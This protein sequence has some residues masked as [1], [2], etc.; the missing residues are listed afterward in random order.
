MCKKEIQE[1]WDLISKSKKILLINHIRMDMDSLWSLSA[2]YDVL[3]QIWK[4]VKAINDETPPNNYNIIWYNGIIEPYMDIAS[5]KPDLI[6]S[7]DAASEWQLWATF[8]N[9]ID[10]FKNT[11]LVVVDHHVS[12]LWFG[13]LNIIYP[14]FSSTCEIVY[15]ILKK[16]E[17]TKYITPKIATA[18]LA[19]VYTDTNI[20]YNSNTN[21]HT[22]RTAA[23]LIDFWAD[24]RKP[25]FEFYKKKT[26]SKSRLWWS[27]LSKRLK[28]SDNKKVAWATVPFSIFEE[29]WWS[30]RDLTWL[31][32]EFFANI[33][34]IEICFL[35][36]ELNYWGVKTSFRCTE[37]HDVS[38]IAWKL[39]W[40]WHKQAAW[41]TSDKSLD[42]VEKICLKELKNELI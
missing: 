8:E 9:N 28:I 15:Y 31:I 12:N 14:E 39:G 10:I 22:L 41:F 27:I 29:T 21:G 33:D 37:Q 4:N 36:F 35:A 6:I 24:F 38:I 2:L 17:L 5:F 25:Y 18:L 19:W 32:S 1:L 16:L 26:L 34:W 11:P 30:D 42:E 20:F 23:D 3:W 7:L 13:S 40:G